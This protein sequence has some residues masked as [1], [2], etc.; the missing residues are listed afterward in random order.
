MDKIVVIKASWCGPCKIYA[1]VIEEAT[2]EI[3]AKGY[4][5][6]ILDADENSSFCVDH[7]VRGIPSTLIFKDGKVVRT[8]VGAQT[9]EKLLSEL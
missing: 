7:G 9:K 2:S 4:D 8:L 5:V 3:K 6:E 1:P